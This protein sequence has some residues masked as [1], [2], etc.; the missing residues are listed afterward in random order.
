MIKSKTKNFK[1]TKFVEILRMA[2]YPQNN[3]ILQKIFCQNDFLS[4]M[5]ILNIFISNTYKTRYPIIVWPFLPKMTRFSRPKKYVRV[6]P[7]ELFCT[8]GFL[9]KLNILNMFVRISD[10]WWNGISIL[11]VFEFLDLAIFLI[12]CRNIESTSTKKSDVLFS[13]CKNRHFEKKTKK[14]SIKLVNV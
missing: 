12:F 8:C 4:K 14:T 3:K 9:S 1:K 5:T 7:Y 2:E 13:F 10:A 11:V 6:P